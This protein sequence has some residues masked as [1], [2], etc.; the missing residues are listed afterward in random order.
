MTGGVQQT[1]L[2][3]KHQELP[4]SYYS[5]N[6]TIFEMWRDHVWFMWSRGR[7]CL[8]WPITDGLAC[9]MFLFPQCHSHNPS[10]RAEPQVCSYNML[11][12]CDW[13]VFMWSHRNMIKSFCASLH[14]STFNIWGF[15]SCYEGTVV[16]AVCLTVLQDIVSSRQ[17]RV[18]LRLEIN[19]DQEPLFSFHMVCFTGNRVN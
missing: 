7:L 4:N 15:C 1:S 17:V 10:P 19:T 14:A 9:S 11:C 3:T 16:C 2:N 12:V 6:T 18:S 5:Y 8:I 13:V